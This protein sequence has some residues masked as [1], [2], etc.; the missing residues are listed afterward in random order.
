MSGE[1]QRVT[2]AAPMRR[3]LEASM[4]RLRELVTHDRIA[5]T[6]DAALGESVGTVVTA[7]EQVGG[8]GRQGRAWSAGSAGLA[9]T[10]VLDASPSPAR[11][12]AAAVVVAETVESFLQR[13]AGIKWP[14]DVFVDGRKIAG[15]LIEQAET[16]RVGIGI[17]IAQ[18]TWPAD[19]ASI[20]VSLAELG[21]RVSA[22]A[23]LERLMGGIDGMDDRSPDAIRAAFDRRD[24]L[25]GAR[26]VFRTSG[27]TVTGVVRSIDPF[28]GL[29]VAC[30][31]GRSLMLSASTTTVVEAD[32]QS[33]R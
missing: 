22:Q 1:A 18:T 3:P 25:T 21:V 17:N 6:Q 26:G 31:D 7:R 11:A 2:D 9:V 15:I 30:D 12:V 28:V 29:A 19:L 33:R 23:V 10:F 20:A 27:E 4:V 8:R 13:P 32:L 5:S 14:N 24:V 16:A